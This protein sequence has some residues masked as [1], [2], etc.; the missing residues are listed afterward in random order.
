MKEDSRSN[1]GVL[2][3]RHLCVKKND[4]VL[5]KFLLG[6]LI[7]F[8]IPADCFLLGLF[9]KQRFFGFMGANNIISTLPVTE[10]ETLANT[11]QIP[12]CYLLAKS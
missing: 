7:L 2:A 9:L 10:G 3:S 6:V 8:Y 11:I 1:I 5:L 12:L 4:E